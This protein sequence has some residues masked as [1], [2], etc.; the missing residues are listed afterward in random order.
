M[1]VACWTRLI[2][3]GCVLGGPK[4]YII[5]YTIIFTVMY[6]MSVASIVLLSFVYYDYA[7]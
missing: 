1:D 6:L 2:F 4:I 3:D 5:S 7:G